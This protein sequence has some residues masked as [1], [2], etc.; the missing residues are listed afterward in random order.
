VGRIALAGKKFYITIRKIKKESCLGRC[1]ASNKT[2]AMKQLLTLIFIFSTISGFSQ[3]NPSK[4][5]INFV[6]EHY[7]IQYPSSWTL[8]TS[9]KMGTDFIVI[10]PKENDTDK[11]REN[12]NLLVQDLSGQNIDLNKYAEIT[13]KQIKE[14][15][16]DGT[17]YEAK[18]MIKPDKSEY[19]K[20]VYGMTQGIFKLKFEQYYFIKN[21]KA[22][23]VTFTAE[24][25]N[26][27]SF[28]NVAEQILNSFVLT[29]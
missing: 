22:F 9:K 19:Y 27:D 4:Q 26:F 11:F 2:T 12:V 8:D 24:L 3:N 23:I 13:Q 16:T 28:L 7:K 20:M 29:K 25:S 21:D 15:V 10:S 6:Q 1:N 17:I 14:M 18:K 5:L